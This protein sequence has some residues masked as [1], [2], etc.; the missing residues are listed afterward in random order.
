M[1]KINIDLSASISIIKI[2]SHRHEQR[3]ISQMIIDL[4]M[5]TI[6][7]NQDKSQ[8]VRRIFQGKE[9]FEVL[10]L[11]PKFIL[12]L[13]IRLPECCYICVLLNCLY[14]SGPPPLH[15]LYFSSE[16]SGFQ[17]TKPY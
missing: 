8:D 17:S 15:S 3:P 11:S 10:T 2:I 14:K 7:T 12:P 4:V 1:P 9:N 16:P 13:L 6:D 5:W